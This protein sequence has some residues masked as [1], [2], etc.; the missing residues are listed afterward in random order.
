LDVPSKSRTTIEANFY[1]S[2]KDTE[3]TLVRTNSI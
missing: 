1:P 3:T 2:R